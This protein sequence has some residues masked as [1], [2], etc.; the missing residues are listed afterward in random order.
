MACKAYDSGQSDVRLIIKY[1]ITKIY[2]SNLN[3]T[4]D[5]LKF[6]STAE[7][8]IIKTDLLNEIPLSSFID[9]KL[10]LPTLLWKIS[11]RLQWYFNSKRQAETRI[12]SKERINRFLSMIEHSKENCIIIGHGFYFAQLVNEMK[13]KGIVG[14]MCKRIKNEES[15]EF[16]FLN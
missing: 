3:R 4:Q 11:G 13:H 8:D 7:K 1:D 12:Q 5:T 9:T 15:R 14:N 2:V 16:R 10:P 6:I